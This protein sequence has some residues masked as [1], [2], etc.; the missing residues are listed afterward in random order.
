M[1]DINVAEL[2]RL[3][4]NKRRTDVENLF[5]KEMVEE[6]V[7]DILNESDYD[8]VDAIVPE[9]LEGNSIFGD[10]SSQ[11]ALDDAADAEDDLFSGFEIKEI[12]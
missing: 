8:A 12:F 11:S 2:R 9:N 4:V 7:D 3:N 6:D 5:L 1:S 10:S